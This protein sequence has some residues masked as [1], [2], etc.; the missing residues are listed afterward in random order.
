MKKTRYNK[1]KYYSVFITVLAVFL[2]VFVVKFYNEKQ[3]T[4]PEETTVPTTEK[5]T[6]PVSEID[7]A[8]VGWNNTLIKLDYDADI[9]FF[10]DSITRAS[11]FREYFPYFDI[12]NSGYSGDTLKGMLSRVAGVAAVEPEKVFV[13]GGINGLT[14]TNAAD[15]IKTYAK[16]LDSLKE[17]LPDAEI[18]VQSVLP[19]SHEKEAVYCHNTAIADFNAKLVELAQEKGAVFVNLYPLYELNGE[20][21]PELTVDGIHLTPEAYDLWATEIEQYIY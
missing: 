17:A 12:V 14:D 20:M 8:V 11:D 16:L 2:A 4:V 6:E 18:Y 21:N 5:P 10:G 1:L 15:C 19:V 13:L 9:V 3:P 7:W